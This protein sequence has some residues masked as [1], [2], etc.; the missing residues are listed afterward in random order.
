MINLKLFTTDALQVPVT[1]S[2]YYNY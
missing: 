2:H 1:V